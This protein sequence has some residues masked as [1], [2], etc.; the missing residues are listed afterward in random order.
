MQVDGQAYRTV[1][2]EG[3]TIRMIN[4]PL[5]PHR[6]EIVDLPDYQSTAK[7]IRTMI[8]R[9]APAI[10]ATG[11]FGMAQVAL[12]ARPEHWKEDIETGARV[13]AS[14]RPTAQDLFHG[15]A[16]VRRAIQEETDI[17]RARE[18]AVATAQA[19]A[20]ESI[21]ACERIG[22]LGAEFI[23]DGARILTHCNAGWL[24]CVDWG[25]AL[26]PIYHAHRSGKK[27]FV[28]VDETRPWCQGARLT[29][30]EMVG[31]KIDHAVIADN[32]AG[33]F[34]AKGEVDLVIVGSDRIARNGDVA[35]KLGTYE[36]AVLAH[37]HGIPFYVAAPVSTIDLDCPT[38]N[39][40]PIEERSPEEV[41]TMFGCDA[42]GQIRSIRVAPK[43]SP[44]RNPSFDV[45]P[46]ELVAAIV[47][48]KGVFKP[49]E[50]AKNDTLL[51]S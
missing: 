24:A 38:G 33:Y 16:R 21:A 48:E 3:G 31:E 20:N 44:A 29:A 27:V 43:S 9:G 7:A 8:V 28:W 32:A 14:T 40:I 11:A 18:V 26:A 37:R 23:K 4:Q 45:T 12:A 51:R 41:L 6:F 34:M 22:Q 49:S 36:K 5:I 13:L 25:T 10:G 46:A 2:M 30:W 42:D 35:N 50:I 39:E 47:T 17:A 15:I 19:L 1:W